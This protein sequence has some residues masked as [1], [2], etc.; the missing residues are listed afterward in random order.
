MYYHQTLCWQKQRKSYDDMVFIGNTMS[1]SPSLPVEIILLD[2]TSLAFSESL[3]S[4]WDIAWNSSYLLITSGR[5]GG[6]GDASTL[7]SSLMSHYP[8]IPLVMVSFWTSCRFKDLETLYYG[9]SLPFSAVNIDGGKGHTPG[10][11]SVFS[12]LPQ[13]LEAV[14]IWMGKNWF[15]LNPAKT[16]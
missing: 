14:R 1:N 7:V 10:H 15:T 4:G 8:S 12:V 11:S 13:S 5:T 2:S 6:V 3:V 16:M 9:D